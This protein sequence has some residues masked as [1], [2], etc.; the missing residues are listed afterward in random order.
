M[1]TKRVDS[2]AFDGTYSIYTV[3]NN[4]LEGFLVSTFDLASGTGPW[5]FSRA[6]RNKGIGKYLKFPSLGNLH[7]VENLN[8]LAWEAS[9]GGKVKK[10]HPLEAS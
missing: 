1:A 8:S 4:V 5:K 9:T 3:K 7:G 2:R 6:R 10:K